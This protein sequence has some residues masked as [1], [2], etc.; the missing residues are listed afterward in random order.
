MNIGDPVDAGQPLITL[1][2]ESIG[3]LEYAL[4]YYRMNLDL[5]EESA[6]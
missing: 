2:G 1:H 3:E 6:K 4:D 5:V